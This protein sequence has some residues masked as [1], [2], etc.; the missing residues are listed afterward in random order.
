MR[1]HAL[2][3]GTHRMRPSEPET[4]VM[5]KPERQYIARVFGEYF[6]P[7][8]K[9]TIQIARDPCV[10]RSDVRTLPCS[11]TARKTMRTARRLCRNRYIRLL[12][13]QQRQ[14]AL[15]AVCHAEVRI[16]CE[17]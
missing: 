3:R 8:S 7:D 4:V 14:I 5:S 6:L 15:Q 13:R 1:L 11:G 10:Q 17:Q 2:D 12:E 9:S 16:G